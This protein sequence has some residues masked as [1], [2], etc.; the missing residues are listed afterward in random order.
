MRPML[1]QVTITE[2]YCQVVCYLCGHEYGTQS[3]TIHHKV[4]L[5]KKIL[6]N[7]MSLRFFSCRYPIPLLIPSLPTLP[8]SQT[9]CLSPCEPPS[10]LVVFR[11][12]R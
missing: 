10:V 3:L 7:S 9:H 5:W 6:L 1:L 4:R 11:A 8:P 12:R 2:F